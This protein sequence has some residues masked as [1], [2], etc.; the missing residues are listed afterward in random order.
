MFSCQMQI[1]MASHMYLASSLPLLNLEKRGS[2]DDATE[3][4]IVSG[5]KAETTRKI[6]HSSLF[7]N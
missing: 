1:V 7:K 4:Q 6:H 3:V 2:K 5:L